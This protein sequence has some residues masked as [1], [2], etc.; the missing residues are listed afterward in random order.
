MKFTDSIVV[1]VLAC[2]LDLQ[3]HLRV[4]VSGVARGGSKHVNFITGVKGE[5]FTNLRFTVEI[6]FRAIVLSASPQASNHIELSFRTHFVLP[7]VLLIRL[8]RGR[9]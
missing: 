8:Q 9:T 6:L 4:A 2:S 3:I 1:S 5:G 7:L